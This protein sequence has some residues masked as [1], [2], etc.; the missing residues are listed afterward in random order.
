[1]NETP[2]FVGTSRSRPP[3]EMTQGDYQQS[4]RS[5][6]L[7]SIM[8]TALANCEAEMAAREQEYQKAMLRTNRAV[9]GDE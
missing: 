3:S 8:H 5:V 2:E 7:W 6:A 9:E 1:V 4:Q